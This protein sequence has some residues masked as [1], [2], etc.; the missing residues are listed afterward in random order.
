MVIVITANNSYI[1][2]D[3]IVAPDYYASDEA[4]DKIL[5]SE[6]LQKELLGTS[7]HLVIGRCGTGKEGVF[8]TKDV[9]GK[10]EDILAKYNLGKEYGYYAKVWW[11][12]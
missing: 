12:L 1:S 4:F 2:D 9:N 8:V 6:K 10:S 5:E 7:E 3:N 11:C